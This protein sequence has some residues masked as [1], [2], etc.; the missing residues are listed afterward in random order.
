MLVEAVL[1]VSL[2][3]IIGLSLVTANMIGKET[4]P[5]DH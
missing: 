5:E 4:S 3:G 2:L 1:F